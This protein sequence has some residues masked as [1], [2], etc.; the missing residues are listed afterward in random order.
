MIVVKIAILPLQ[1]TSWLYSLDWYLKDMIL[2]KY[3][4]EITKS[5]GDN[6]RTWKDINGTQTLIFSG[7]GFKNLFRTIN[8]KKI[9]QNLREWI[10]GMR[11][12]LFILIS[13][14]WDRVR[15][16]KVKKIGNKNGNNEEK[17]AIG[18]DESCWYEFFSYVFH[19]Q[20]S[21]TIRQEDKSI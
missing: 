13:G 4:F 5:F 17:Y 2:K 18:L 7:L 3:T 19:E 6:A 21:T 11:K 12:T 10:G 16:V 8:W 20:Q 1:L 14:R 9:N 15:N